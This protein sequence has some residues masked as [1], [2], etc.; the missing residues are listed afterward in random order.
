MESA[1]EKLSEALFEVEMQPPSFAVFSNVTGEAVS[2]LPE[3]RRTLQDQVTGT[4]RWLDCMQGIVDR[5]CDSLLNW[6]GWRAG[7]IIERTNK[8]VRRFR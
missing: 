7:G 4:V 2:T 1:Y 5:G 6:T 3:I 8:D